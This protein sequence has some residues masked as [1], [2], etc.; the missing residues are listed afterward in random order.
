MLGCQLSVYRIII[1]CKYIWHHS[2]QNHCNEKFYT[3]A[4]FQQTSNIMNVGIASSGTSVPTRETW[5]GMPQPS[6]CAKKKLPETSSLSQ[7]LA[8]FWKN[9]SLGLAKKQ[10]C[11]TKTIANKSKKPRRI[12]MSLFRF[13]NFDIHLD[14]DSLSASIIAKKWC[15][16]SDQKK[17]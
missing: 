16:P 17:H 14:A 8:S 1:F 10:C 3:N 9:C 2:W 15:P 5:A 6:D 4:T 13:E 7:Q 11:T 12:C